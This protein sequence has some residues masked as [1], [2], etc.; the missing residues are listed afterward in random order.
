MACFWKCFQKLQ[1]TSRPISSRNIFGILALAF[2]ASGCSGCLWKD[3]SLVNERN[4]PLSWNQLNLRRFS[5]SFWKMLDFNLAQF[6]ALA[7]HENKTYLSCHHQQYWPQKKSHGKPHNLA[8]NQY[9][10]PQHTPLIH[11]TPGPVPKLRDSSWISAIGLG[12]SR[13]ANSPQDFPKFWEV[14]VDVGVA[15]P[16]CEWQNH[17]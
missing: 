9:P 5:H 6:D 8:N 4:S 2:R 13:R 7:K 16:V 15:P 14:E 3:S 12:E 10:P 17:G 11:H 1:T